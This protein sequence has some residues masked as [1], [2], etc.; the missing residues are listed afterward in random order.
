M[1]V[2]RKSTSRN[3]ATRIGS[4][5]DRQILEAGL[6][7]AQTQMHF[8]AARLL[9]A[10]TPLFRVLAHAAGLWAQDEIRRR[11]RRNRD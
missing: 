6:L 5:R 1:A 11:T 8:A 4:K 2:K 9:D 10:I 7:D 3:G